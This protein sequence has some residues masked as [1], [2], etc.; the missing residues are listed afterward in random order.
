[1]TEEGRI[2]YQGEHVPCRFV[3]RASLPVRHVLQGCSII[4]EPTATTVVPPGWRAKVGHAGA[5]ILEREG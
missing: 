1:M 4:E 3:W 2:V 5:L